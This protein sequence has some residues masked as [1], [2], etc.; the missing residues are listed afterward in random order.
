MQVEAAISNVN[1]SNVADIVANK[2]CNCKLAIRSC[3]TKKGLTDK[4]R[5]PWLHGL[6]DTELNKPYLC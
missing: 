5:L 6:H 3:Y 4:L 1:V 2:L